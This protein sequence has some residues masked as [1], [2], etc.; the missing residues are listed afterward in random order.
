MTII[1]AGS[2]YVDIDVLA[3]AMAYKNLCYLSGNRAAIHLTGPFNSTI[4]AEMREWGRGGINRLAP[5]LSDD[6]QYVIVDVSHPEFL[7]SFVEVDQVVE[8]YDH[9]FGHE[10]FWRNRLGDRSK[11]E[12]VGACA[13]L[14]WEAYKDRGYHKSIDAL[15][16]NFLYA[17]IVANTL[18]FRASVTTERDC[19]SAR[20][21]EAFTTLSEGW[22]VSY[23]SEIESAILENL[24]Q[25]IQ[26]DTKTVDF[27]GETFLLSQI[28]LWNAATILGGYTLEKIHQIMDNLYPGCTWI[29]SLISIEEGCNYLFT[30]SHVV[31]TSLSR[32]MNLVPHETDAWK[33]DRL[34][35]RKEILR[36]LNEKN[37]LPSPPS[38]PE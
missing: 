23:Y 13:T 22:I 6:N 32:F 25:S 3:C 31:K 17:A 16:A 34:W 35:L 21:L 5:F 10:E 30:N 9:H 7:E 24:P 19:L 20:E 28:E 1:T 11:I 15:S 18:N 37:S 8:V 2:K 14:I 26:Y 29:L 33:S 4:T 36:D 27:R 38:Q 12:P